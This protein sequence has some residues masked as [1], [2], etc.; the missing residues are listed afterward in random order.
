VGDRRLRMAAMVALL[1]IG[2]KTCCCAQ[3]PNSEA[4]DYVSRTDRSPSP[5]PKGGSALAEAPVA[6]EARKARKGQQDDSTAK[7]RQKAQE[8]VTGFVKKTVKGCPCILL[9][10]SNAEPLPASYKIDRELKSFSIL[11]GAEAAELVCRLDTIQDIYHVEEDSTC[12]F[13]PEVISKLRPTELDRLLMVYH[14]G[15]GGK[16]SHFCILEASRKARD[17]FLQC[18]RILCIYAQN[19]AAT[20]GGD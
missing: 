8:L 13:P 19:A 15:T 5:A 17:D 1:G 7:E 18:M 4:V 20:A 16:V 9:R 3:A 10:G 12:P 11:R 14:T 6:K 2:G